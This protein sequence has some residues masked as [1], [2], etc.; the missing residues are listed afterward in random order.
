MRLRT[1]NLCLAGFNNSVP[2][3]KAMLAVKV[4]GVKHT[5]TSLRLWNGVPSRL[6]QVGTKSGA[7]RVVSETSGSYEYRLQLPTQ[8]GITAVY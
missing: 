4:G 8:N 2:A 1:T 7:Q 5:P 6:S 3:K